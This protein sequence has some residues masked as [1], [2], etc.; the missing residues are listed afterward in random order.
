M[1]GGWSFGQL[2]ADGHQL[3]TCTAQVK[4]CV[5]SWSETHKNNLQ[6][7]EKQLTQLPSR[8]MTE[9]SLTGKTA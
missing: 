5:F 8:P 1:L 4:S 6:A 7:P 9:V 2:V 3:G